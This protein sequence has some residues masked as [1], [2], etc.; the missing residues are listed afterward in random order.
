LSCIW[1]EQRSACRDWIG[2]RRRQVFRLDKKPSAQLLIGI[3]G[4]ISSYGLRGGAALLSIGRG[5][6]HPN[7]HHSR[8]H[9]AN[10]ASH[11]VLPVL[12][13]TR[14]LPT[15]ACGA[16]FPGPTQYAPIRGPLL[17]PPE[18]NATGHV[19]NHHFGLLKIDFARLAVLSSRRACAPW[20]V[21][22]RRP[23]LVLDAQRGTRMASPA[24]FTHL[25]AAAGLLPAAQ[26]RREACTR[27]GAK[28]PCRLRRKDRSRPS[29]GRGAQPPEHRGRILFP[30]KSGF[31]VP[32][33]CDGGPDP[34]ARG[35]IG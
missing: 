29:P 15:G 12:L 14:S 22:W 27:Q 31:A 24:Q 4:G 18:L 28:P 11:E 32:Y 6:N 21:R 9:Y 20:P 3:A 35:R 19:G 13:L 8:G 23:R 17:I 26:D 5:T 33:R 10:I 2:F 7:S 25:R 1:Y 34:L 30:K 16:V